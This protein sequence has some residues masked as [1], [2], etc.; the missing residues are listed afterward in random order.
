LSPKLPICSGEEAI[1]AFERLGYRRAR[2]KGS[3][4]F[5]KCEGRKSISVPANKKLKPG[6]LRTIIKGSGFSVEEFVD[7]L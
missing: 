1:R 6:T 3:H 7:A 2:Q 4:V 5:L